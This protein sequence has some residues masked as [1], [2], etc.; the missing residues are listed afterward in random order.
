MT[1]VQQSPSTKSAGW[2][3]AACVGV[4]TNIFFPERGQTARAAKAICATCPLK[5]RCLQEA[6]T[7][8]GKLQGVWGGHTPTE[9]EA[10]K[11]QRRR[12]QAA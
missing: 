7:A 12:A 8:D 10:I 2:D 5:R 9:R 4:D 1:Q 6:L 3:Q 11:T